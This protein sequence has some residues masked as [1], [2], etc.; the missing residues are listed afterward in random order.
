[1]KNCFTLRAVV[2][3]FALISSAEAADTTGGYLGFGVGA[4]RIDANAQEIANWI[5]YPN[6]TTV[7]NGSVTSKLYGGVQ[8]TSNLGLEAFIGSLGTYTANVTYLF[9]YSGSVSADVE[10]TALGMTAN[11]YLPITP[12]LSLMAKGGLALWNVKSSLAGPGGAVSYSDNGW[13]P[14]LGVGVVTTITRISA[15]V[16]S[17]STSTRWAKKPPRARRVA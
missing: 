12:E 10:A 2:V 3:A 14:L 7:Q 1:M 17:S 15:R 9:P 11:G 13:T 5:G 4:G 16:S 8:V 6:Y